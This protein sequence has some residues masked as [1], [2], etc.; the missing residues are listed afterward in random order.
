MAWQ[1]DTVRTFL[2][3]TR[4]DAEW[5]VWVLLATTGLRRD[6]AL[7][8]RWSD[9]DLDLGRA[10]IVQTVTAIGWQIHIGHVTL[11]RWSLVAERPARHRCVTPR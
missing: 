1:S 9:V 11:W 2:E 5:P 8:L 3:L 4:D 6:E 7:G 10:Q